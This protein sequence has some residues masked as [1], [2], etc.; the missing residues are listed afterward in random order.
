[1]TSDLAAFNKLIHDSNIPA[2][3]A[4]KSPGADPRR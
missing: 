1:M 3:E 4:T 2:V